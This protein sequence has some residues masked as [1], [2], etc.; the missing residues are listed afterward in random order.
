MSHV[1]DRSQA[2]LLFCLICAVSGL[3]FQTKLGNKFLLSNQQTN[4]P[5]NNSLIH[6]DIQLVKKLFL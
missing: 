6:D 1:M 5:P 3:T 4:Q 2:V